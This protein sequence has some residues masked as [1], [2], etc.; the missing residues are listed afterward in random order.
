MSAEQEEL[1]Q[2]RAVLVEYDDP[3]SGR[4]TTI[5]LVREVVSDKPLDIIAANDEE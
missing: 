2:V 1:W 3:K 4:T 5:N